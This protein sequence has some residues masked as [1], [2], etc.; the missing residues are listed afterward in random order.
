LS[1]YYAW[2]R[3]FPT[4]YMGVLEFI[5]H[6]IFNTPLKNNSTVAKFKRKVE[7]CLQKL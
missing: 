2:H 1:T 5:T 7:N 6:K 4:A 3:S